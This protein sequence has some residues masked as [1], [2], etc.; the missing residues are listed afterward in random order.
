MDSSDA[1][2][3]GIN[4]FLKT[5]NQHNI[6]S[7]MI[8][9]VLSDKLNEITTVFVNTL[10]FPLFNHHKKNMKLEDITYI[11]KGREIKIGKF[12]VTF[13]KFVIIIYIVY[14][15]SIILKQKKH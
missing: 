9:G 2:V 11:Y 15:V 10:I 1:Y 3:S 4:K 5:L 12:I 13:I 8:A 7:I 14:L 6:I